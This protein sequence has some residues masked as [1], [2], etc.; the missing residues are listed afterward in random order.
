MNAVLLP[1]SAVDS[2]RDAFSSLHVFD[3]RLRAGRTAQAVYVRRRLVVGL[4]LVA[5]CSLL[6]FTA[7]EVLADRGNVPAS[8]PAIR[9]AG[10]PGAVVASPGAQLYTVQPGDTL[11]EIAEGVHGED[12]LADY[13]DQLVSLNGG[14]ALQPGQQLFLP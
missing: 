10:N 14:T 3:V 12:G 4:V 11:W 9:P 6:G 13:V 5:L 1:H 7:H 8:I 2:E